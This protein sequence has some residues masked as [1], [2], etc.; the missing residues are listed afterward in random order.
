MTCPFREWNKFWAILKFSSS[1]QYTFKSPA[2]TRELSLYCTIVYTVLYWY[3]VSPQ[4]SGCQRD[5][6]LSEDETR[7]E[8]FE[9]VGK[10]NFWGFEIV[11]VMFKTIFEAT[12]NHA[13]LGDILII[14][15]RVKY[16]QMYII[17]VLGNILSPV[18]IACFLERIYQIR[19][20]HNFSKNATK[21]LVQLKSGLPWPLWWPCFG[22]SYGLNFFLKENPFLSCISI[23]SNFSSNFFTR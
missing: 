21:L 4:H 20:G 13:I 18:L 15:T 1:I 10:R 12:E 8:Y 6:I 7:W 3:F 14:E 17:F 5:F 11:R 9:V 23:F 19:L 22:P 2:A 16:K